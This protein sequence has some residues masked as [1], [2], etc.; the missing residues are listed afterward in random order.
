MM[1]GWLGPILLVLLPMA[2]LYTLWANPTSAGE[3][4]VVYYYPLRVMAGRELAAGRITL[5]T[6]ME[7]TGGPLM[8]DPQSA[9]MHPATWLFAA[10]PAKPAYSLSIF[11]AFALAGGGAWLYLRRLGL[12][13]AAAMFGAVA[14]MFCGYMVGHRVH[15]G[16]ILAA[17]MLPWGLW[18]V[19]RMRRSTIANC[20]YGIWNSSRREGGASA[21]E[22]PAQAS[23]D[24]ANAEWGMGNGEWARREGGASASEPPAQASGDVA[25]TDSAQGEPARAPWTTTFLL[26]API[27]YLALTAGHW[28]TFIHLCMAWM[29]YLLLRGRPFLPSALVAAGAMALVGLLAAPQIISTGLLMLQSTR[30]RIGYAEFGENSYFPAAAVLWLFPFFYG[31]RTPNQLFG[32]QWWGPWHQC[33][34]LGYAGLVTLVLALAAVWRLYRKRSPDLRPLPSDFCPLVRVWTWI[35]LGAMVWM[36]GYYLPTYRLVHMLPV[37]GSVRASAR[38]VLVLDM[39]LAALAAIC[40]H[41]VVTGSAAEDRLRRLR[42]SIRRG[43]RV[44][45]PVAMVLAGTVPVGV[46]FLVRWLRVDADFF[47]AFFTGGPQDLLDLWRNEWPAIWIPVVMAGGAIVVLGL[48]LRAPRRRGWLLL[49][50]LL[51]DLFVLTRFVDVPEDYAAGPHPDV[52]PAAEW[53]GEHDP[54]T[55]RYLVWGLAD[56]CHLRAGELLS[57]KT[58]NALGFR[59]LN[60]YGPFL[61]PQFAHLFGF[62]IYGYSTQPQ[63][64]LRTNYLLS[65]YGVKYILAADG[66][67][68]ELIESVR[69]DTPE[70]ADAGNLLNSSPDS[71][72]L[73]RAERN[74][75]VFRLRA[76]ALWLLS[77][78][79][80]PLDSFRPLAAETYCLSFEARAPD[81]GAA[82][83]VRAEVYERRGA[84]QFRPYADSAVTAWPEQVGPEWRRFR[85]WFSPGQIAP[86][87]GQEQAGPEFRVRVYTM[88]ERPIEVRN[89]QLMPAPR[90]VP[91]NLGGRLAEGERVYEDLTPMGLPPLREGDEPVHIYRNRLFAPRE[92]S[93]GKG[94][95]KEQD[96]ERMKWGI[97]TPEEAREARLPPVSLGGGAGGVAAGALL[98][99]FTVP[100]GCI[101]LLVLAATGIARIRRRRARTGERART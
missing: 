41:T 24:V 30:G 81:G 51:A 56:E 73:T 2:M 79:G 33:E 42:K 95:P 23:G 60:S 75:E 62:R 67:A 90:P 49:L 88:S 92:V 38:M 87:G 89:V 101:Y 22:P 66:D 28:P 4:D 72:A 86:A 97:R 26:L 64:L 10:L 96:I 14:F 82:N 5:Y 55:S 77:K 85:G 69:I 47:F 25:N 8:A 52:S 32:Q 12:V 78:I 63:R 99:T 59:T 15:L 68:R 70:S 80:Q 7:A 19:E 17:C 45:L 46:V 18:A 13:R 50:L 98:G 20:G 21:S 35:G 65:L 16:A 29:A 76:P 31:T 6:N 71:W 39:A 36:L 54:D 11:L 1:R 57:P 93:H 100:A 61:S 94:W 27:L 84:G 40:I 48:W 34:M 83:F 9:W 91:V 37:F 53:L 58:A 74:G 43:A 3:D 44:W